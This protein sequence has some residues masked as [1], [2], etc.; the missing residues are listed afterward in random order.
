MAAVDQ[1]K[2][3]A[4]QRTSQI[5]NVKNNIPLR[6]VKRKMRSTAPQTTPPLKI[7]A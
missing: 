7:M 2:E 6:A 5:I 1:G 3:S 4:P